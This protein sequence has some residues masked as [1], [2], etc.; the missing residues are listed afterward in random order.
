MSLS[1]HQIRYL[2]RLGHQLK[3]VVRVGQQGVRESIL[4]ALDEALDDH[5]L[6]KVKIVAER[7]ERQQMLARLIEHS[8][9]ELVQQIGQMG[10]LFRRNPKKPQILLPQS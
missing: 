4:Q 2:R 8:H 10:V 9:A 7:S 3:P 6:I 1:A 5:E